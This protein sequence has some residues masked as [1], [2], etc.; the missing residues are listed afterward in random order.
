LQTEYKRQYAVAS[1]ETSKKG[2]GISQ[3]GTA[4][5]AD[6]HNRHDKAAELASELL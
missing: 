5:A 2:N 6:L 4:A 1:L 3:Q